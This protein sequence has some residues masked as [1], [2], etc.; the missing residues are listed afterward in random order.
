MRSGS[1]NSVQAV[2]QTGTEKTTNS[3][4][5]RL[6]C[7][8]GVGLLAGVKTAS[9]V[10]PNSYLYSLGAPYSQ[11]LSFNGE[12]ISLTTQLGYGV[13]SG[14]G[15]AYLYSYTVKDTGA[16]NI[17]GFNVYGGGRQG[18]TNALGGNALIVSDAGDTRGGGAGLAPGLVPGTTQVI[19]V[20]PGGTAAGNFV[21]LPTRP[22][23]IQIA[24]SDKAPAPVGGWFESQYPGLGLYNANPNAASFTVDMNDPGSNINSPGNNGTIGSGTNAGWGFTDWYFQGVP[25]G[26]GANK[27]GNLIRWYSTA[28]GSDLKPGQTMTFDLLSQYGPVPA[29]AFPDPDYDEVSLGIDDGNPADDAITYD[30]TDTSVPEP[31]SLTALAGAAALGLR[32][33]RVV[34]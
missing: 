28:A 9:G 32:R 23:Y 8:L 30:D 1:E 3:R 22:N 15:N 25:G 13:F 19:P 11:N 27:T 10:A 12:T 2:V 33:R 4:R 16:S 6:A 17:M 18:L 20:T 29:G 31:A 14:Y 24:S 21:N 5:A 7:A 26:T 34:R